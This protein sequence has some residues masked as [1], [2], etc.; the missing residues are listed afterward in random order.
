M[1]GIDA[2]ARGSTLA[3]IMQDRLQALI[4][5]YDASAPL[6]R[7]WTIPAPWYSHPQVAEAEVKTVFGCSWQCIGRAAQLA[8]P[9]EF[10]ATD[11]AGEPIIAVRGQ[12]GR[13]RAF[14]NVCRHHAAAVV[15]EACGRRDL[16]RCPYHG[17]TYGLDG[18]LKGTP[19]FAA[20][21]EFDPE[22]NGLV[23]VQV[24]QWEQFVFVNLDRTATSVRNFFGELADRV[25]S[26]R[27]DA[28]RFVER[29]SYELR[30][31][32]KVFVDNYLD[33]GYHINSV[34]PGLAGILDYSQ[35]RSELFAE[36]SVQL[37]PT[38]PP[39]DEASAAV[40]S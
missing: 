11:V 38:A 13:L 7:A 17:W 8:Q 33:G 27:L 2:G 35:Y 24:E 20:V 16:L 37:S 22:R 5:E 6:E 40:A 21:Q 14:F 25:P 26:L 15:S 29:R 4:S 31:N 18:A 10:V 19:D 36:C 39:R 28:M 23:P 1:H 34:H 30:C 3:V 9:G 12:D 32:W